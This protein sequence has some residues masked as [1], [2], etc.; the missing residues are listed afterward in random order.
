MKPITAVSRQLDSFPEWRAGCALGVLF[1]QA[2]TY[3]NL[4]DT[5]RIKVEASFF[6]KQETAS[7]VQH[8]R[9]ANVY[10][11]TEHVTDQRDTQQSQKGATNC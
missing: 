4:V 8:D 11:A 2:C 5:I 10:T 1:V 7:F 9:G 3:A 6:I